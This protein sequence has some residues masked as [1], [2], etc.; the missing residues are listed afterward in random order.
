M[1]LLGAEDLSLSFG[2]IAALDGVTIGVGPGEIVGLLGPNGAGKSTLFNVMSGFLKPAAGRVLLEGEDIGRLLPYERVEA[3]IGRT[4]QHVR[5]FRGLSVYENLLVAQHRH[6]TGGSLSAMLRLPSRRRDERLARAR[7]EEILDLVD[8]RAWG[9]AYPTELSYGTMRFLELAS[10]LSL[11]PKVLL[12]DEPAS[13]I[14]Q[15]E[16]EALGPMIRRVRD[17]LGCA[18]LLIEH[19]MSLLLSVAERVYAMDFGKVIAEGT[20][21]EVASDDNVLESYLGRTRRRARASA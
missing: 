2:G 20:P 18:L 17:E 8:L 3:G 4:F 12:L 5:L 1:A 11:R 19:D 15:K 9:D 6:L 16:V 10:V 7:V 13:G 21:D 14:A